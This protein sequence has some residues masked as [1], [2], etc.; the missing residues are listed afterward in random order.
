MEGFIEVPYNDLNAL[1]KLLEQH[2]STVAGFLFEPVQG[3]AGVVVPDHGYLKGSF[4]NRL[5]DPVSFLTNITQACM[6]SANSTM[7]SLLT[8]RFRRYHFVFLHSLGLCE[9][10]W[11]AG[12]VVHMHV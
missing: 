5:F 6:T 4:W 1:E 8:M 7:S 3:E 11:Y 12:C 10:M 9:V 2:G